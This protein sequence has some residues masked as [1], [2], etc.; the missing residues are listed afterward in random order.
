MIYLIADTHFWHENILK[1]ENRPFSNI[2]EM[3]KGL[4]INWNNTV[5]NKD[6]VYHLGDFSWG[7][8]EVVQDIVNQLNG[9]ITLIKGNH[10]G[11]SNNWY[12]DAGFDDVIDG[13]MILKNH[14]LLTHK[15]LY[16]NKHMPFVNI[17]GHTHSN[18]LQ[19]NKYFS[20]SVENIDYKPIAFKKIQGK[21]SDG[22]L[23]AFPEQ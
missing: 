1:Y 9:Y 23:S 4:I 22:T 2:Q 17:H 11:K 5:S 13:G 19:G 21:F 8:K 16:M 14:F 6:K 10:D 3:N 20:V 12:N 15:P 18:K 7:N